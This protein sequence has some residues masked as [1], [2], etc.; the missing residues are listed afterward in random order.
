MNVSR[1]F[2]ERPVMTALVTLAILMFGI[3][4]YRSLPVAAPKRQRSRQTVRLRS[5]SV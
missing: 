2:I 4:G 1:L 3:V 5:P